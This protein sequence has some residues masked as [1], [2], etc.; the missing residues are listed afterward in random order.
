M[1][2]KERLSNYFKAA[3]PGV[4][5]NTTEETRILGD[6]LEA[7][8]SVNKGIAAWSA[9]EGLKV[10]KDGKVKDVDETN[11]PVDAMKYL[12]KAEDV[13]FI[14]KDL[15]MWPFDRDPILTRSLRDFLNV[16]PSKGCAMVILSPCFKP[17]TTVEKL[18]TIMDYDL[19]S[20]EELEKIAEGIAQSAD[21]VLEAPPEIL[22]A[23]GGLATSEAE[24]ALALSVVETGGFDSEVIYREKV[25]QVKKT[26]LLEIIDPDPN[27][28]DAIGGLD[29]LKEWITVRKRAYTPEAEKYGL[30]PP[31][32]I[33]LVGVPGTGKSLSAKAFG[34]ALE[35]PTVR[36]DIGNLFNSLVG[37]SEARTREALQL[38]EAMA[39]CVLWIDEIDKGFAGSGGSGSGDSGVTRRVFGSVISW[40]QER[41]R[42]VFMVATANQVSHLPAEILRKGRF[43]EIF[44]VDLPDEKERELIFK[45]HIEKRGRKSKDFDLNA[46][47]KASE[48]FTGSEI[49]VAVDE[50]MFN[51]FAQ[52][53]EI[54]TTD[55]IHACTATTPLATTAKE[56]IDGI[57]KWA[58]D[59]ARFASKRSDKVVEI[60]TK[61]KIKEK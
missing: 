38:A 19:P 32:G 50:A 49:E 18:I 17:H 5:I 59:R 14:M 37:E 60:N 31:K 45:I 61:R 25:Q 15:H 54:K 6:I 28:L 57:R 13:I 12:E 20:P 53:R 4:A 47:A 52:D 56:Q 11:D 2:I 22:K 9:T 30:K 51:A 48:T 39:P 16:A 36:L 24:N 10:I 55:I 3:F 58:K 42:P 46:I 41:K 43:D 26:G 29:A 35:V 27:G 1:N 23:L 33:L 8:K 40:M 34:T 44:A 21:K 7:A